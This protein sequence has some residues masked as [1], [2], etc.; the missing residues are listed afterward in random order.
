MIPD[1]FNLQQ[2]VDEHR[3]LLKPPVG[4]KCIVDG[5][6]IVMIV[7]GPNQRTDYHVE[8]GPEFFHQLEGEMVLRIQEDGQVRDIPIKAGEM[9]YL[10]PKVPHS[11]QRMAGSVGLV[12]ERKRRPGEKDGLLWYCEKCNHPLFSEYFE[13]ENIETQF[14]AVFDRFYASVARRTCADCGHLNPAPAKYDAT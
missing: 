5:D 1:A 2:W 9:F 14:Q 13:L 8:E 6:F 11:P 10:P 4:N 3:H 12:I 7:G